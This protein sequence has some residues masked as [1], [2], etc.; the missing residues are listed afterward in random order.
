MVNLQKIRRQNPDLLP[1]LA[2]VGIGAGAYWYMTK[3][4]KET[5]STTSV[6]TDSCPEV[7]IS[8]PG[9][10]DFAKMMQWSQ[11][12]GPDTMAIDAMTDMYRILAPQCT[13]PPPAP[14]RIVHVPEGTFTWEEF[15][16]RLQGKTLA[17]AKQEGLLS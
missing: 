11:K 9:P 13:W 4:K 14:G 5:S 12:W 17:Q 10:A 8:Q 16:A 6:Q 1:L 2:I 7:T 3:K 15:A